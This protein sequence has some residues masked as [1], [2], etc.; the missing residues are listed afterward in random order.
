MM[1]MTF[2][3]LSSLYRGS[4]CRR[5]VLGV[6]QGSDFI[7]GGLHCIIVSNQKISQITLI[8]RGVFGAVLGSM[9][10]VESLIPILAGSLRLNKSLEICKVCRKVA[11]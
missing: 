7:V 9:K 6:G 4:D 11:V 10:S 3:Y 5:R 1:I 8:Y 2:L